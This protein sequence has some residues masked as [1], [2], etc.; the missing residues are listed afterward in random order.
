MP[1]RGKRTR[2]A[3]AIYQDA[4]GRSGIV[5]VGDRTKEKRFSLHTPITEIQAWQASI[6][7]SWKGSGTTTSRRG[8]LSDAVDKWEP[9]ERHLA[10]WRER[11]A[12]LRAWVEQFGHKRMTAITEADVRETIG[13]CTD[14][15]LAPKTI[16]KR[17]WTLKHLYRIVL[18]QD[19]DTPVDHVSPPA[20]VRT[21]ITP[22]SPDVI[23][24]VYR[25][26]LAME[27]RRQPI[28]GFGVLRDA[29]TRARF[30][31]LAST[32]R[33]PSEIMRTQ[34]DDVDLGRREWRVRDGKGGW[35]EGL[36]LNDDMLVAW[37]T[38]AQAD[39]WG[40]YNTGSMARVLR[41]CG[42]PARI[43][44]YALRHSVGIAL[45]E[46]GTDLADVSG[47]L[48]HTD[49]RTTRSAYVPI[50]QSRMQRLSTSLAGRLNGWTVTNVP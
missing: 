27:T 31:V 8:T 43:K 11:R 14:D 49:V 35:S 23:L 24:T 16:R 46:Q 26:L 10:S 29:K 47:W 39:A 22:V 30:M 50:L 17:L 9:Q 45:S 38:F 42:W 18:G 12:E 13:V 6:R 1:R 21:I 2:I 34:P 41:A 19:A 5:N 48:G 44:P 3:R 33:R 28:K 4:K 32:G 25:N 37:T 7:K 20:K 40:D 15:K 36:F